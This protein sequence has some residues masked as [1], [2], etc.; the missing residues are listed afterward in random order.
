MT[1]DSAKPVDKYL[2]HLGSRRMVHQIM[3]GIER[4]GCTLVKKLKAF[5]F[6]SQGLM[7]VKY[8]SDK[9]PNECN[10]LKLESIL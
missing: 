3:L 4:S 8:K 6:L 5:V 10:D 2:G 9:C 1:L 7:Q